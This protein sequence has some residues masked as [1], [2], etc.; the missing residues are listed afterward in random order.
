MSTAPALARRWLRAR[1][2]AAD[3]AD[4]AASAAWA[5]IARYPR[6][7]RMLAH[8]AAWSAE[9]LF[10]LLLLGRLRRASRLD[11][12]SFDRLER[13]AHGARRLAP[14]VLFLL[15]RVPLWE[16]LFP[17]RTPASQPHPL[18]RALQH[19]ARLSD[20]EIVDVLVIGSGAGGAPLA[21]ALAERGRS[22]VILEAGGL[23]HG[24]TTAGA[25]E[26]YYIEQAFLAGIGRGGAMTA[27]MAGR[28]VG[29]TTPINSGTCLTPPR[30]FL[31]R[32]DALT[33][34]PFSDGLLDGE[35]AQVAAALGIGVPERRLLGASAEIFERGLLRLGRPGAHVLPRNTPQCRG[36]GRCPFGCPEH[37]K[38]STDIAFLP[39]ALQHGAR[40]LPQTR[41]T[42]I[43]ED[44]HGVTVHYR[45]NGA[46]GTLRARR[47]VLAAGALGTPQLIRSNRLGSHWRRAGDDLRLHPAAKVLALMPEAV[48]GERGIAQGMGYRAPELPR[49]VFEGIFTPKG[50]VAPALACAGREADRWLDRYDHAASF[51][52]MALD[53]ASGSIR[54]I[55]GVPLLRYTLHPD[56]V[57][58]LA[59]G[60]KLMGEAFFAAGAQRVLLPLPGLHNSFG[61]AAELAHFDPAHV[62]ARHILCSGFHPQG[63]AG[64]GRVIDGDLRL[65]GSRHVY[66]SDASALPDT[67]G[68]NPQVTIMA[69]SLRLATHLHHRLAP[70][71]G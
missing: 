45:R 53:R 48:H 30:E 12:D 63:T 21:A 3:A 67:P 50:V 5:R 22:V 31:R 43:V 59:R 46:S 29:G 34:L 4:A 71:T 17:E 20:A 37:R 24:Q 41:A 42:R 70:S 35:L 25:L 33:G 49:I 62:A 11:D 61:S 28:N 8:I 55:A 9:C 1:G 38:H 40:L 19:P 32:W 15:L 66:V 39:Q 68:V 18:Q 6:H 52:M 2:L 60:M 64:I 51:G 14:R 69:L 7:I 13:R 36:L 26:H 65:L 44:A 56:D 54:W 10:P 58:D 47:C 16:Q 57:L 27:L 23:V